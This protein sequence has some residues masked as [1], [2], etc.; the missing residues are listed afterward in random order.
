MIRIGHLN[1]F[2]SDNGNS[3][4]LNVPGVYNIQINFDTIATN[5]IPIFRAFQPKIYSQAAENA[6]YKACIYFTIMDINGKIVPATSSFGAATNEQPK[7]LG[8]Y[9]IY[10]PY[11]GKQPTTSEAAKWS[12]ATVDAGN[13]NSIV[14]QWYQIMFGLEQ[15][16]GMTVNA[17]FQFDNQANKAPLLQFA[18]K[19][20][21]PLNQKD[22]MAFENEFRS[23]FKKFAANPVGRVLLY[24]IL[25][26]IGRIQNNMG[27]VEQNVTISNSDLRNR[28][29]LRQLFILYNKNK[30]AKAPDTGIS[31]NRAGFAYKPHP[32]QNNSFAALLLFDPDET[33]SSSLLTEAVGSDLFL[34]YEKS[35]NEPLG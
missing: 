28:N 1:Q 22:M 9:H 33:S 11:D 16:D 19:G 18:Y 23:A 4:E 3:S 7:T 21:T 20:Q 31:I 15:T 10:F 24:R 6:P 27:A 34:T 17:G 29:E 14:T 30:Q 13:E 25:I 2:I 5:G 8:Y 12:L 26:E 35:E 32:A